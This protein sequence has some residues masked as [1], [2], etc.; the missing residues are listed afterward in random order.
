MILNKSKIFL[1][2]ASWYYRKQIK[3]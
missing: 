2:A 3:M 1:M